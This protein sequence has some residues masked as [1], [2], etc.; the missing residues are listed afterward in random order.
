MQP[1]E[2][3]MREKNG[4]QKKQDQKQKK[5]VEIYPSI[6]ITKI[7]FNNT[8]LHIEK[9]D[10]PLDFLKSN[11]KLR[12]RSI[13]ETKEPRNL[14]VKEMKMISEVNARLKNLVCL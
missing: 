14:R 11:N 12:L 7:D 1:K 5:I 9:T 4:T 8:E 13:S 3:K 2:G 6:A 10:V